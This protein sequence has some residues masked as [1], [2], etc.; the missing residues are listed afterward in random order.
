MLSNHVEVAFPVL[1]AG[2]IHSAMDRQQTTRQQT[3]DIVLFLTNRPVMD[4]LV[5][6]FFVCYYLDPF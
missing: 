4:P 5:R 1:P 2:A 3:Q 6:S